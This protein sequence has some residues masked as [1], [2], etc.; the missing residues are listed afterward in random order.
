[1][2]SSAP[3]RIATRASALA[4]WQANYV[5]GRIRSVAPERVVEIVHVTTSG[6]ANQ[7]AA[8]SALGGFGLFTREV[9]NALRDGRGDL[10]VHS[11]KD[12]PTEQAEGLSLAAVP[13][14]EETADA[15]VLA[16]DNH[17]VHTLDD[18][19]RGAKVGTGSLR[20][21][22]QILHHR[23]DLDLQEIRG[24]VDTRLRKLD[25]GQYDAIVLAAAGL[26]RLGL[27]E[28]IRAKLSPPLMYAAVGQGALGLECR[29]E[30]ADLI[31]ILRSLDHPAARAR[32][33]A[34]RVLLS[35]LRAGCHAP[36]GVATKLEGDQLLLEAVVLSR[37]GGQ[38]L[39][40]TARGPIAQ[41]AQVGGDAAQA[42]LAEGAAALIA[43][44]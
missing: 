33:T 39:F 38:R 18:L 30:D 7:T 28:R 32:V 41:A 3:I 5:A 4:L 27:A 13:E 8:L 17:S 40:T 20:R 14:R 15:L 25:E 24:N 31:T 22:A 19:P 9:Q 44:T 29:T 43:A 10:A 34:E 23:P 21:R 12:L 16:R 42:L 37:D 11:L 26:I 1:M 35:T 6:D 2:T 36:V